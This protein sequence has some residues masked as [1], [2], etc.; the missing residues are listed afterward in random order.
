M[1]SLIYSL[2]EYTKPAAIYES[3]V[4]INILS[5]IE[6]EFRSQNSG[7]RMNEWGIQTHHSILAPLNLR[8]SG[9]AKTPF[10]HP[11]LAQNSILNSG[12]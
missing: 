7:V 4:E 11:P 5:D 2:L 10:I 3:R 8:F 1:R 12:S 6:E 9:G